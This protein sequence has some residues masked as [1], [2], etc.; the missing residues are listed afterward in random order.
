MQTNTI[1]WLVGGGVALIAISVVVNITII[2]PKPEA[3]AAIEERV[4]IREET[5]EQRADRLAACKPVQEKIDAEVAQTGKRGVENFSPELQ[6]K[7]AALKGQCTF[8]GD[9]EGF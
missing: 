1:F 4:G 3:P 7:I 2:S 5:R 8:I 6:E 9:E